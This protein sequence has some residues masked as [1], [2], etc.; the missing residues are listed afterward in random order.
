MD[1]YKYKIWLIIKE[2]GKVKNFFEFT[3]Q[4]ITYFLPF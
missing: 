1:R 2:S 4:K 3:L